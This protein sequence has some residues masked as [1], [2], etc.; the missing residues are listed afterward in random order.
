MIFHIYKLCYAKVKYFDQHWDN[1][2][3]C[4]YNWQRGLF[5]E[6]TL[7]DMEFIKHLSTG[8][9]LDLRNLAKINNMKIFWH[10]VITLKIKN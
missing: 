9:V 10:F 6:T 7:A 8:I 1:F 5:K 4:V 2:V 3:P